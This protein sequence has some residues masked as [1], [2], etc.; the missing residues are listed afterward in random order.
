MQE[1]Q[2]LIVE[3][4]L[5]TALAAERVLSQALPGAR[6]FRA[7]GCFEAHLLVQMY[8]IELFLVDVH[9]PDGCGLDL[10]QQILGVK[11]TAKIIVMT[12]DR[13]QEL[14]DRASAFGVEHVLLKPFTPGAL[15]K[16]ARRTIN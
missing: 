8:D 5:V 12:A 13:A 9:L 6:I 2:I 4:S 7:Q 1:I 3:D 16:A 11:P 14:Q 15:G 10:I